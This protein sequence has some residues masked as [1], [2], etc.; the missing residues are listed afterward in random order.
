MHEIRE[1]EGIEF[2]C[3]LVTLKFQTAFLLFLLYVQI[4][5][6]KKLKDTGKMEEWFVS[7][8]KKLEKARGDW[9]FKGHVMALA[10]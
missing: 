7:K 8:K 4:S 6:T 1:H 3:F 2:H 9:D 10:C 5:H